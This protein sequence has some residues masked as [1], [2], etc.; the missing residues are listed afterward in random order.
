MSNKLYRFTIDEDSNIVFTELYIEEN[1]SPT[2]RCGSSIAVVEDNNH[3]YVYVVGGADRK[4]QLF[5]VWRV[6][7]KAEVWEKLFVVILYYKFLQKIA[8]FA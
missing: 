1:D 4:S 3:E 6:D 5:D 7:T 2:P 8:I